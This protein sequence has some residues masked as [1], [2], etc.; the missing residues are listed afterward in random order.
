MGSFAIEA[1]DCTNHCLSRDAISQ[2]PAAF[3]VSEPP[4]RCFLPLVEQKNDAARASFW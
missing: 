4:K 1:R 3:T 2:R